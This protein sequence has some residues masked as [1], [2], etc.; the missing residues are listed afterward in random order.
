MRDKLEICPVWGKLEIKFRVRTK[1]T[2]ANMVLS[3]K[4]QCILLMFSPLIKST[5]S[6]MS[7]IMKSIAL[8]LWRNKTI[9]FYIIEGFLQQK[10]DE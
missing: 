4:I 9:F 10:Y 6:Y 3:Y 2:E 1:E 8:F 5:I 7:I